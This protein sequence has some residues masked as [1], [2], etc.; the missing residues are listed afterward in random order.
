MARRQRGSQR[1]R[2]PRRGWSTFA[3]C[4]TAPLGLTDDE[5]SLGQHWALEPP[6]HLDRNP[7][8]GR[9]LLGGLASADPGLDVAWAQPTLGRDLELP[10][11]CTI[12]SDSGSQWVINDEEVFP[13]VRC[14]QHQVLPV[15]V[16]ADELE[17][18]HASPL[19]PRPRSD[20]ATSE[21]IR[22][23]PGVAPILHV[24]RS[25]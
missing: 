9:D 22:T 5:L 7:S 16:Y 10:E 23:W 14:G 8:R 3:A 13:S 17:V 6:D 24:G 21:V 15:V 11:T 19:P 1:S 4:R 25:R 20:C 2:P 18:M 12:K